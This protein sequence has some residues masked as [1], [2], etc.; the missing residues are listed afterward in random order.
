M[1]FFSK[2][3]GGAVRR[4]LPPERQQQALNLTIPQDW[5]IPTADL[6]KLS[7]FLARHP[8]LV[9]TNARDP[10]DDAQILTLA[11]IASELE[12]RDLE[13]PPTLFF[14]ARRTGMSVALEQFVVFRDKFF[15]RRGSE[16]TVRLR[17]DSESPAVYEN[18]LST[19]KAGLF[20]ESLSIV[21]KSLT[22]NVL[23]L[24]VVTAHGSPVLAA[25][26]MAAA[27]PVL[28]VFAQAILGP[29]YAQIVTVHPSIMDFLMRGGPRYTLA[30]KK[31]LSSLKCAPGPIDYTKSA[32]FYQAAQTYAAARQSSE[33]C[34]TFPGGLGSEPRMP[35]NHLLYNEVPQ[36]IRDELG[37]L[38]I[39]D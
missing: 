20:F 21:Q 9:L 17:F 22:A 13:R 8:N 10:M 19:D 6:Q 11:I 29:D 12:C 32:A 27:R 25:F 37:P 23:R 5:S 7:E 31:A 1:A 2:L 36:R 3:F 26:D 30:Y 18:S 38:K 35:W 16:P 33:I 24:H 28:Q 34:G 15:A 39:F 4:E 14:R